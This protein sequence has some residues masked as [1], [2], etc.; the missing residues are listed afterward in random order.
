MICILPYCLQF[1]FIMR[2]NFKGVLNI[3]IICL[4]GMEKYHIDYGIFQIIKE[5]YIT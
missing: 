2:V 3:R 5:N 4:Y 1:N